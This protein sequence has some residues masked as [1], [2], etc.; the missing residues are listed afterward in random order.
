MLPT[1]E[2]NPRRNHFYVSEVC[3]GGVEIDLRRIFFFLLFGDR[4]LR[5][6]QSDQRLIGWICN[7][8]STFVETHM[9][10]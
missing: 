1:I 9:M 10:Y 8:G 4:Q 5:K 7:P 3:T 6:A 2:F